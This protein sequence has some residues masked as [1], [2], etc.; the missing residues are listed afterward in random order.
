MNFNAVDFCKDNNI[1]YATEGKNISNG[2][3]G[4]HDPF[5]IDS[6]FHGGIN[7]EGAYF[8]SWKSGWHSLEDTIQ[9]LLGVDYMQAKILIKEYTYESTIEKIIKSKR[10]F[11]ID[12]YPTNR[13]MREFIRSRRFN[14]KYLIEKYDI[15][16]NKE[17]NKLVIPVYYKGE[18]VSYQ[19]RNIDYKFYKAC[20]EEKALI[21]YKDILYN[22]DNCV[23]DTVVVLEGVTDVWRMGDNSCSTFGTSYTKK[24]LMVLASKF[25]NIIIMFDPES[26]AQ[27]KAKKMGATL[28]MM[29]CEVIIE[30]N[31]CDFFGVKDP[32]EFTNSQAKK[33]MRKL[34]TMVYNL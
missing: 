3:V 29:G 21:N 30:N 31:Y 8:Y 5:S 24:Q 33:I 15:R 4:I 32:G 34:L 2:W 10:K 12:A 16:G 9:E 18:I 14:A 20:P 6:S 17:G 13:A 25:K 23:V 27:A 11:A 22:L 28:A 26:D 7:P 1:E 19:E